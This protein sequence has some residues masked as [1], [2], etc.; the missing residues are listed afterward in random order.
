M[1]YLSERRTWGL[2]DRLE[3]ESR[4]YYETLHELKHELK[5]KGPITEV[6]LR[7]SDL[8]AWHRRLKRRFIVLAVIGRKWL[9]PDKRCYSG[10]ELLGRTV[11]DLAL[12]CSNQVIGFGVIAALSDKITLSPYVW[13]GYRSDN[14]TGSV[15][16]VGRRD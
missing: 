1:N 4:Q 14:Q 16:V 2:W 10:N 8:E 7:F 5:E 13:R 9:V 15:S 3:R 12:H 11:S 6:A